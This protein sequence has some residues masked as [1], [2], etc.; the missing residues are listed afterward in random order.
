[1][2]SPRLSFKGYDIRTAL[3][4]NKDAVKLIGTAIVGYNAFIISGVGFNW[5]SF[6]ISVGVAF[7]SLAGKLLMDAIDYFFTEVDL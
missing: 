5:Q 6:L 4:R 1:M 7:A 3:F 2:K